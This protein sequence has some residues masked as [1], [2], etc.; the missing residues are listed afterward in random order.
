VA[1]FISAAL[2]VTG[3]L[4]FVA[5]HDFSVFAYYRIVFGALVLLYVRYL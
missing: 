1:A 3:F 5:K 2:A 4:R